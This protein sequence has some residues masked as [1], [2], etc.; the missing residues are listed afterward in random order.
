MQSTIY[1]R[2][3]SGEIPNREITP[4]DL[5]PNDK[6]HELVAAV[7]TCVFRKNTKKR[8]KGF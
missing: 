7:I 3:V 8:R 6:G 2:V 5:H 1:P 4:D